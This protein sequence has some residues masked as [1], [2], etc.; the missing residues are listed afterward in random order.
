[1]TEFGFN[2]PKR[3]VLAFPEPRAPASGIMVS[4]SHGDSRM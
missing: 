3:L 4:R 2:A 1:M